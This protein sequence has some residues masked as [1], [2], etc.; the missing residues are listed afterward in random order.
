[1]AY[2]SRTMRKQRKFPIYGEIIHVEHVSS[3]RYLTGYVRVVGKENSLLFQDNSF[4]GLAQELGISLSL[5]HDK[6]SSSTSSKQ[7]HVLPTG[8][9]TE[10]EGQSSQ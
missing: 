2:A 8:V 10:L 3:H 9:T 6:L 7:P 4:E 1:M 5:E